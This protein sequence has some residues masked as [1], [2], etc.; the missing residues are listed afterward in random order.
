MSIPSLSLSLIMENITFSDSTENS[1][2]DSTHF[3]ESVTLDSL[4]LEDYCKRYPDASE[5]L[6]YDV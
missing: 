6:E 4:S 2:Q 1:E 3:A 5:C